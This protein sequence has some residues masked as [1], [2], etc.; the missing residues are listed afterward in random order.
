MAHSRIFE[1]SKYEMDPHDWL[2]ADDLAEST[3]VGNI[4]DYVKDIDDVDR[5]ESIEWLSK[6][7]A[8]SIEITHDDSK[9][10]LKLA[11][12]GKQTYFGGRLASLKLMVGEMTIDEFAD[13]MTA[14]KTQELINERYSFYVFEEGLYKTLDNFIRSIKEGEEYYICGVIDYHH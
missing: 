1:V 2:V 14:W 13:D 7:T 11:Q 9:Y 4:A 10:K 12:N 6:C 5:L 3:F 8:G